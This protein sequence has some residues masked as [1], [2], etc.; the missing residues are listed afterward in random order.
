MV[1]IKEGNTVKIGYS[2]C[3][4]SGE[5]SDTWNREFGLKIATA[6]A[7]KGVIQLNKDNCEPILVSEIPDSINRESNLGR[8]A[9]RC[10]RY[11]F[12]NP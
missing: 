6:R 1:A 11:F 8:F 7:H 4:T 12:K 2:L 10:G 3:K 9:E 5:N